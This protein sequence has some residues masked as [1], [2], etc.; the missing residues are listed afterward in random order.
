LYKFP[1]LL[2]VEDSTCPRKIS[3]CNKR[4]LW[5]IKRNNRWLVWC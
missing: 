3:V 1:L 4:N 5:T 2:E